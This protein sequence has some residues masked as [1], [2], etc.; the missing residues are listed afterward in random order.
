MKKTALVIASLALVFDVGAVGQQ[1]SPQLSQRTREDLHELETIGRVLSLAQVSASLEYKGKCSG[2]GLPIL[3]LPPI[4]KPYEHDRQ[5]PVNTI[6]SMFSGDRSMEVYQA[7][8]GIIRVV[9]ARAQTDILHVRIK[10]LSFNG[11]FDVRQAKEVALDAPE[12]QSFMQTHGIVR[13]FDPPPLF[14]STLALHEIPEDKPPPDAPRVSG[15][16]N[17]VTLADAL[18]YVLKT[19]PGI[20]LYQDCGSVDGRPTVYFNVWSHDF[21][22]PTFYQ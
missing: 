14:I 13:L 5:N 8:S 15:E 1:L 18:D 6:R 22:F 12:V 16:L 19:F 9:E 11:I 21:P 2:S 20:W 7:S 4:R 17:D 10:H 3:D